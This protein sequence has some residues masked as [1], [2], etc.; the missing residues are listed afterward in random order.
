MTILSHMPSSFDW[1]NIYKINICTILLLGLYGDSAFLCTYMEQA[2]FCPKSHF[3][4]T[5]KTDLW[6]WSN[7]TNFPQY[8]L[9]F[10]P[11]VT[12]FIHQFINGFFLY[13]VPLSLP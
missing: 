5:C 7:S 13:I 12:S 10:V 11:F 2:L 4:R 3:I 1:I 8:V 9:G 6:W